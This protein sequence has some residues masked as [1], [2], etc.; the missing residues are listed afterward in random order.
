[1]WVKGGA[2]EC[3]S[4]CWVKDERRAGAAGFVPRRLSKPRREK[5]K[6]PVSTKETRRI[7]DEQFEVMKDVQKAINL[8]FAGSDPSKSQFSPLRNKVQVTRCQLSWFCQ[9]SK[10]QQ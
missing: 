8:D 2:K 7:T 3:E 5:K 1:M 9:P 4:K 10:G 6:F